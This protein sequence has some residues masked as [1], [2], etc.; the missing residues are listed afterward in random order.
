MLPWD[1]ALLYMQ[2][3]AQDK[4]GVALDFLK[5]MYNVGYQKILAEFGR[6]VT[7]KTVTTTLSTGQRTYVVPPDALF[8]KTLEL[9]D[10]TT[11]QPITE[12]A[13]DRTWAYMKSGNIQGRPTNYHYKPRFG[14]GGGVLELYP[15][16]SGNTYILNFTYEGNDKN[17]SQTKYTTGTI[18]VTGGQA[19]ITGVGT[20]FTQ[21]M[22]LRYLIATD[23]AAD[24]MPYRITGFTDATHITLETT[25]NGSNLST[26]GYKIVEI[27]ALPQDMQIIPCHYSL[28]EWWS[29][30]GNQVK[31]TEFDSKFTRGMQIAKKTHSGV[32]RDD[33]VNPPIPILPFTQYP[34]N[35]P[36]SIAE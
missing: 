1:D 15:I 19:A 32:T 33:I 21:S 14:V 22:L 24:Q 25:Y 20:T 10:G 4:S 17:L 26:I 29:S 30:R 7:E 2:T 8:P 18:S 31:M 3:A 27:P 28:A 5:A 6:Q 36:T 16:P 23:G 11:V 35:Y 9:I 34:L 12:V 13:S